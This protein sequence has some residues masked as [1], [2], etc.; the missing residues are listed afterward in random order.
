MSAIDKTSPIPIYYQLEQIVLDKIKSGV[1]PPNTAIPSERELSEQFGVSRMTIRQALLALTR[2]GILRR[3]VGVGTFVAEPRI[4]QRLTRLTGFSEDMRARGKRASA[5][6]LSVAVARATPVVAEM[7]GLELGCEVLVV[8]RLRLADDEPLAIETSHL[9][10]RGC[11]EL[12]GADLE[13]SLYALLTQKYGIV[14]TRARQRISAGVADKREIDL[15]GL[16]RGAPV[17]RLRRVTFDQEGRRFEY[18]ESTYRADK[19]VFDAEL[20]G[21]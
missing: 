20:V 17:L 15:L 5:R 4:T 8:D 11:Q 9:F 1:W 21:M 18:V 14:P 12:Q 2:D 3:E 13:G 7:L 6:V 16:R 10:F 19:Y